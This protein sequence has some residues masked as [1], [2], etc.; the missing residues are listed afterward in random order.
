MAF[1]TY[2]LGPD[3]ASLV[4][5]RTFHAWAYPNATAPGPFATTPIMTGSAALGTAAGLTLDWDRTWSSWEWGG[6]SVPAAVIEITTSAAA[7]GSA[8]AL[9]G[10]APPIEHTYLSVEADDRSYQASIDEHLN[11]ITRSVVAPPGY[12]VGSVVWLP[13]MVVV[14][15]APYY[16]VVDETA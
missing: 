7:V 14:D 11:L 15:D 12:Q 3:G 6:P 9:G 13:Y 2:N 1:H 4:V 16:V 8:L 10:V 5:T